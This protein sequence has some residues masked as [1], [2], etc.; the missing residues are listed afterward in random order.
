[1][2]DTRRRYP[3]IAEL[4]LHGE[5]LGAFTTIEALAYEPLD[6]NTV[7]ILLIHGDVDATVS[8]RDARELYE[9]AEGKRELQHRRVLFP[10]PQ[11]PQ[12]GLLGRLDRGPWVI[13]DL[14]SWR[15]SPGFLFTR[16]SSS[17][18]RF[19]SGLSPRFRFTSEPSPRF[20][21]ARGLVPDFAFHEEK[22]TEILPNR[23]CFAAP[24][25]RETDSRGR[26]TRETETREKL[27]RKSNALANA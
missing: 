8:P 1:M 26:S 11:T 16:S 13:H 14:A 21:F 19:A 25:P 20:R 5:S 17:R 7:P 12:V 10:R 3:N 15:P 4:G 18:F 24:C 6:G 9:R 22:I 27:P 2:K 23:T